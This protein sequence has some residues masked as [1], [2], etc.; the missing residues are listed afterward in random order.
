MYSVGIPEDFY[1]NAVYPIRSND[2]FGYTSIGASIITNTAQNFNNNAHR[3]GLA[4]TMFEDGTLDS[5]HAGL[6][7]SASGSDTVDHTAFVNQ[8]DSVAGGEHGE[9]A[10][11]ERLNLSVSGTV[12]NFYTFTASDESLT[13][14]TDYILNIIG[15]G[16]DV[17]EAGQNIR[18]HSD[19][20]GESLIYRESGANAYTTIRDESPWVTTGA[21]VDGV[22][23]AR[24]F[25]LYITYT[26]TGKESPESYRIPGTYSWIAPTGVTSVVVQAWG[27]GGTG[28]DGSFAGAGGGG[29]GAYVLSTVSVT[30]LESYT[31][32]VGKAGVRPSSAGTGG[33]GSDS[34]FDTDV[35]VAAG[36]K[37]GPGANSA[38]S[39]G[40]VGGST[41]DSTGD[42]E[43]AGGDGGGGTNAGDTSGG[44]GG[45]G[46]PDGAG[47]NGISGNGTV[48]GDGGDGDNGSGGAGG[49]GG[50]GG[51]GGPGGNDY[52]N[53]GGGG[54][55]GDNGANSGLGGGPGGGGGGGEG[56]SFSGGGASGQ[57]ILT[58][59][60]SAEAR[61]IMIIE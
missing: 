41:D 57:V 37:G 47:L 12:G 33:D 2:T 13:K 5:I 48:G 11:I 38:D 9:I 39:I 43:F 10:K 53:G 42:T 20:G 1:D 45:A 15:D 14:G 3:V 51:A 34:T 23:D 58:Y 56:G 35:V 4:L 6:S 60:V 32:I 50:N 46:G 28:G 44:G 21:S 8:K 19:I 29:G 54:G 7:K 16:I 24:L 52:T 17:F 30:P 55:G 31:I 61:R 27:A 22:R 26:P 36:G 40:G 49:A 59:E 25:S 18:L